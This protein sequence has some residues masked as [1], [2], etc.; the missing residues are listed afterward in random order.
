M[1]NTER[2]G[3]IRDYIEARKKGGMTWDEFRKLR[4]ENKVP[5]VS[6]FELIKYRKKLDEEREAKLKSASSTNKKKK[7]H[8]RR[9]HR[10]KN[11]S[12]KSDDMTRERINIERELK[13]KHHSKEKHHKSTKRKFRSSEDRTSSDSDHKGHNDSH[14][15]HHGHHSHSHKKHK[16]KIKEEEH[17]GDTPVRLSEFLKHGSSSSDE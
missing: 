4:S 6:D 13:D 8:S 16:N 10:K 2:G 17:R 15:K 5:E 14:R 12:D 11:R 7:K 9:E 3:T 1:A